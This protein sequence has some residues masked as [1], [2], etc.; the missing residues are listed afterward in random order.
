MVST[1]STAT[2]SASDALTA[3]QR[4]RST[5]SGYVRTC[6]ITVDYKTSSETGSNVSRSPSL[7]AVWSRAA[8]RP[9]VE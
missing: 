4:A 8:C 3:S 1:R 7:V 6:L 5:G 2:R 9:P